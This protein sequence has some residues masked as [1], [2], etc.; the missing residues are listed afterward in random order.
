VLH[1]SA[2][3]ADVAAYVHPGDHTMPADAGALM[4]KFFKAHPAR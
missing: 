1:P 4:V 3:G 2:I